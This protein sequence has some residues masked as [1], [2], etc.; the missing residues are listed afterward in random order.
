MELPYLIKECKAGNITAQKYLFDKYATSFFLLCRRYL[1]TD[2]QA[3][4]TMMSGY[5]KIFQS[6][7]TFT[8]KSDAETYAWMK[9]ILVNECLM[10]LRKKSNYL[11]VANEMEDEIP[12]DETAISNISANEIF[13]LITQLPIGY[14]T[15][16]NLFVIEQMTHKEI[17]ALLKITEGT[18]KS[19]L[20]K[21]RLMLQ[22]LLQQQN[23]VYVN[24]KIR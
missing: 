9:H 4:D 17:A 13:E 16:F 21:A 19:Q 18:S 15:V 7:K 6:L 22:Q 11:F 5:L 14:R 8:Y 20:N 2:E 24:N 10:E 12:V 3:E 23:K 1:T